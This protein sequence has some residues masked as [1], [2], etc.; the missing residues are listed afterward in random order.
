MEA[1]DRHIPVPL[2]E[3]GYR[4]A[5]F[6]IVGAAAAMTHWS[7]VTFLVA[8]RGASPLTVNFL[9]FI[10]ALSV[11]YFGHKN[12]TFT[13][14]GQEHTDTLPRFLTVAVIGFLV[15]EAVL[16]GLIS[17]LRID[18]RAALAAAIVI[19]AAS[20]YF[21]SSFWAFSTRKA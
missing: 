6:G 16:A 15:N 7:V 1:F 19:A 21:L 17:L 18:Y 10:V 3:T 9:G 14:R 8:S 20:T 2:L 12:W 11:S 13:A 4:L 5:R